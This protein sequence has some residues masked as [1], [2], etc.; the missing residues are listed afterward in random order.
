[1]HEE[2]IVS[3]IKREE[4]KYAIYLLEELIYFQKMFPSEN[5]FKK[6]IKKIVGE[7]I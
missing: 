5:I 2:S 7:I 6:Y 1:L 4:G 3:A